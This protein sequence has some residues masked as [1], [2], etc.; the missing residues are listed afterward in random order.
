MKYILIRLRRFCGFITGFIFFI[1]G[2]LKVIDPVG[3]GLVIKEYLDF[4]HINFLAPL[5]KPFGSILAIGECILG[6]ALI[7]GVWRKITAMAALAVQSAFTILTAALVL[8][9]PEMDCG[10][11]GEAIHL[12]HKETLIKNI[13]I[14]CILLLGFIPLKGLGTPKKRKYI[15]FGI[16][17]I[18]VIA[19]STY[20]WMYLPIMDFTDYRPS[21]GLQ[22]GN[23]F[24]SSEGDTYE[25]VFVYEK[26]GRHEEFSIDRLPDSTWTFISVETTLKSEAE[27]ES[28]ALSFFDDSGEYHDTLACEGKV[29]VIS[30]YNTRITPYKW[31]RLAHLINIAENEGFRAIVLTPLSKEDLRL[32][33]QELDQQTAETLLDSSYTSDYKT[34]IT[35]NR[36]NA[37]VTCISEGYILKKWAHRLI[38]DQRELADI[39]NGDDTEVIIDYST[40]SS[41]SFQAF[42]LYVFAVMLLM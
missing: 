8:F 4:L 7:T 29:L 38:P 11:F 23:A 17:S 32:S 33:L 41:L 19:L 9:N 2:I 16:V 18:S 20:S 14:L 34:L 25:S 31:K 27:T 26:D 3:S 36:S 1:S 39:K 35:L 21:V 40:K 13:I 42:L 15:S 22:S 28:A 24:Q 10:C 30:V 12:T 37:G 5:S 6:T